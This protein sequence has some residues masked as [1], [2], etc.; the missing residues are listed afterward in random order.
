MTHLIREKV[1][2]VVGLSEDWFIYNCASI[3]KMEGVFKA[4]GIPTRMW[5]SIVIERKTMTHQHSVTGLKH[6]MGW[7]R[8]STL[9]S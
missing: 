2:D 6:V 8:T 9:M 1:V 3:Q 7:S 5:V 4:Y